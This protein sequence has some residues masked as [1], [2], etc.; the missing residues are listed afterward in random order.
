M[1]EKEVRGHTSQNGKEGHTFLN[2]EEGLWGKGMSLADSMEGMSPFD[3]KA[4]VHEIFWNEKDKN[5]YMNELIGAEMKKVAFYTLGCKV[6]QYE[7]EAITEL[8]EKEGYQV[9]EFEDKA[10]VYVI[11]TCTVTNLS[12]RKSR[13]MIRRAKSKNEDSIVAVIGCYA[14]T[15]PDEVLNIPGVNLIIG[16][17]DRGK[18]IDYINEIDSKEDK[19]DKVNNIMG[20]R[21]FEELKV[22]AY[23]ERTRAFLKI[24]EGCSQYCAYCIIPYARGPIR[25]RA[26]EDVLK[27]VEKLASAG[28]KEVVLTGIHLTSYGKDIKTTTL[29]DIIQK[30]HKA[31]GIERIRLGSLEPTVINNDF[32]NTAK[33]LKKL[34]PHYHLSLQSGCNETL[35]RMNRKYTVEEYKNSVELLRTNFADVAI[36]TDIMVGFPG[37]TEEEFQQ[38]YNFVNEI[39]FAGT[40]IFK[41]SPRKGTP[42]ATLP[43]QVSPDKKEER[44]NMLIKLGREKTIDFNKKF[45]GSTVAVLFE[46]LSNADKNMVEG[47]TAN[48]IKVL[49]TGSEQLKG[50]IK[51]VVLESI[52]ED[53][54]LGRLVDNI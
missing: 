27:E 1:P 17:K 49:C 9:V 3:A 42:A 7:T 52:S 26:P 30:V 53:Y 8:F 19:L 45:L 12:D 11:N 4:I 33:N 32:I 5:R 35:N 6:N 54:V 10:D 25:S 2:N 16:T 40:H 23:K 31:E 15:A 41:F 20:V 38:T 22:D 51:N 13:Q 37:E 47:M 29:L 46:Q 28:F 21:D 39:S 34:C 43:N 50:K 24:Q 48:Y 18:I 14:Q 44:S 36:T